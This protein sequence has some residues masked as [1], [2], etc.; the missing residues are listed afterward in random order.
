[1]SQA[2]SVVGWFG[3][4]FSILYLLPQ[5]IQAFLTSSA[6]GLSLL[7]IYAFFIGNVF[8]VIY[9]IGFGSPQIVAGTAPQALAALILLYFRYQYQQ[10]FPQS[11]EECKTK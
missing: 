8:W 1:M 10:R 7:T 4:L 9:G 5:V 3:T 11:F 2:S 6:D